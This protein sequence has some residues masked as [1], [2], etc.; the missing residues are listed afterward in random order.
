MSEM[1]PAAWA[2]LMA[3]FNGVFAILALSLAVG[4][5]FFV[6]NTVAN[7]MSK[8][9]NILPGAM[10]SLTYAEIPIQVVALICGYMNI[11]LDEMAKE[12]KKDAANRRTIV[13]QTFRKDPVTTAFI[14]SFQSKFVQYGYVGEDLIT[15][16]KE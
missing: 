6:K 2:Y 12:Y 3:A 16:K 4:V 10:E 9:S 7:E 15:G 13:V 8:M 14:E 5:Y 1:T 11:S